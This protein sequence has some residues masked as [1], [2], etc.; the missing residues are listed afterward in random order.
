MAEQMFFDIE[1]GKYLAHLVKSALDE[2]APLEIS[3]KTFLLQET[4]LLKE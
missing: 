3:D 4:V 1:T 2:V